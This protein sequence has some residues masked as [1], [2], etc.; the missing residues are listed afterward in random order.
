MNQ[1]K[2]KNKHFGMSVRAATQG[3]VKSFKTERNLKIDLAMAILVI[4]ISCLVHISLSHFMIVF[5]L[6]GGVISLELM[7][8]AIE[9]T[10]DLVTEEWH[11]LAKAAKD[12]AAGAVWFFSIISAIIYMMILYETLS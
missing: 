6:I 2:Y 10:V 7:N 11:P 12:I 8:T 5:I 4:I 1:H 9:Q 3:I